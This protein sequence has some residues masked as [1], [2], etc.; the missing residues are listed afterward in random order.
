[1]FGFFSSQKEIEV[2]YSKKNERYFKSIKYI[3]DY[4][5]VE[6]DIKLDEDYED[7][8]LRVKSEN[9]EKFDIIGELSIMRFLGRVFRLYPN[10]DPINASI[11]DMELESID[12]LSLTELTE[13]GTTGFLG[14]MQTIS[15][16]DICLY[17][18]L[19][20]HE[21]AINDRE[22]LYELKEYFIRV[23]EEIHSYDNEKKHSFSYVKNER[24]KVLQ[25]E[26]QYSEESECSEGEDEIIPDSSSESCKDVKEIPLCNEQKNQANEA[27]EVDEQ[28]TGSA[29]N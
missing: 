9:P 20:A 5:C 22:E 7:I 1:M 16:A 17:S 18:R 15:I 28:L 24:N 25:N 8:V 2:L 14:D 21:D 10:K 23:N 29:Q 3:L 19:C 13:N 6:Y 12:K 26:E 4:N 11:V 27:T